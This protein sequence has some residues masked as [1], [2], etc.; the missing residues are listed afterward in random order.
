MFARLQYMRLMV[1]GLL[2]LFT[3][4]ACGASPAAN[5]TPVPASP[6]IIRETV[7]VQV[8]VPPQVVEATV[9][10]PMEAEPGSLV[11]YSGRS[12]SLVAPIIAQF[13]QATGIDVQVRYGS[14]AEIAAALLEEGEQ[15]PADVFFAQD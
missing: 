2:T 14:T 8:T 10:V 6:Q 1:V 4:A 5:S 7:E 9:V 13:S 11:V 15:S 3:L 12:E